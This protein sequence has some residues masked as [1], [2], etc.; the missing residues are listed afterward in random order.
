MFHP[1]PDTLQDGTSPPF[2]WWESDHTALV[3]VLWSARNQGLNLKDN[4]D[5]IAEMILRSR[6]MAARQYKAATEAR[7][8]RYQDRDGDVWERVGPLLYA[9]ADEGDGP[10]AFV[11][12]PLQYVRDNYGPLTLITKEEGHAAHR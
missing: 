7:R 3:H 6:W 8:T 5:K 9:L 11:G 10:G 1:D 12:R 2:D 4:A